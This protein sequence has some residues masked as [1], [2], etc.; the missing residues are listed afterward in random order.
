MTYS[1]AVRDGKGWAKMGKPY[2]TD[3]EAWEVAE[4]LEGIRDEDVAVTATV[5]V[6][7]PGDHTVTLAQ[8]KTNGNGGINV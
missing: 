1:V 2:L 5:A 3:T 7:W 8:H 4:E 6:P